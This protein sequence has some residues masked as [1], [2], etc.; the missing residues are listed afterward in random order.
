MP[1]DPQPETDRPLE[2]PADQPCAPPGASAETPVDAVPPTVMSESLGNAAPFAAPVND[3]TL[4]VPETRMPGPAGWVTSTPAVGG[5]GQVSASI[6]ASLAPN[7]SAIFTLRVQVST[8][9]KTGTM[10]ADTATVGPT[11]WDPNPINNSATVKTTVV[12]DVTNQ[13]TITP[14]P[15]VVNAAGQ[16]VQTVTIKNNGPRLPGPLALVVPDLS[17]GASLVNA[18]GTTSDGDPFLDILSAAFTLDLGK[19]LSATLTFAAPNASFSHGPYR[20]LMGI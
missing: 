1:G 10:I 13:L 19:T 4:P 6:L 18:T 16:F 17:A 3:P 20:V 2:L 5:T 8:T 12:V 7:T 15:I 14:G 9:A 11:T